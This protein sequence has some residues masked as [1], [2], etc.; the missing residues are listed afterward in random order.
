MVEGELPSG[1]HSP[2]AEQLGNVQSHM[3]NSV[4]ELSILGTR[5]HEMAAL[6]DEAEARHSRHPQPRRGAD[7]HMP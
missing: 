3:A 7:G 4:S 5:D 2:S 6:I 1:P